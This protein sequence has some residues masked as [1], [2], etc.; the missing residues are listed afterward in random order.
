MQ[1][2]ASTLSESNHLLVGLTCESACEN[3]DALSARFALC[4]L[5]PINR[6]RKSHRDRHHDCAFHI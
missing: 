2:Q 1:Y 5:Q 6:L 4:F 3:L